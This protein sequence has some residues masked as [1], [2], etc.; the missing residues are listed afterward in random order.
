[1]TDTEVRPEPP[2][3]PGEFDPGDR[4]VPVDRRWLGLDRRTIAP[5]LVVLALALIMGSV[6]PLINDSVPYDDKVAAGDVIEVNG[7]VTFV[8]TVGW[9]ITDGVRAGQRPLSGSYPDTA[10]VVDGDASF[11]VRTGPFQG[12]A[13]AL[14]EQIRATTTALD[15]SQ[16]F[17]FTSDPAGISTAQGAHGVVAKFQGNRSDGMIAAFV[18]DGLGVQVTA[19]GAPD[20]TDDPAD[21]AAMVA[22]IEH[23]NGGES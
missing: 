4:W 8:P 15:A 21:V 23:R 5:A 22:S 7:G 17:H 12:D 14:L 16:G 1:M 19:Y 10:T 3:V 18:F 11:S 2:V 20:V 9:G 13:N 6:L